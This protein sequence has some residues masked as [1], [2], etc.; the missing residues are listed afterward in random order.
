MILFFSVRTGHEIISMLKVKLSESAEVINAEHKR[1]VNGVEIYFRT[2]SDVTP[3]P[4]PTYRV[5]LLHTN[6]ADPYIKNQKGF[7]PLIMSYGQH[8][9]I[10]KA[11]SSTKGRQVISGRK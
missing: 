7:T 5:I 6:I 3:S 9:T 1:N 2:R 8:N 11:A 10:V 4:H